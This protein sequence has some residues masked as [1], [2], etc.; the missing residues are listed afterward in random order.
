[1]ASHLVAAASYSFLG[2]DA[3]DTDLIQEIRQAAK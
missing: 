1:M 3:P 2:A